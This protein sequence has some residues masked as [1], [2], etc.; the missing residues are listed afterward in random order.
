[1]PKT[2]AVILAGCGHRDGSE[3]HESVCT[4]LALDKAG[5]TVK[6]FAPN[7][8]F[9]VTD[10][11]T[12]KPTGQ[13]RNALQ[14]AAR[15]A[16]GEIQDIKNAKASQFDALVLPGGYGAA[17]ILSNF[18]EKGAQ[19]DVHPEVARLLRETHAAKK[20]IGA[21]CIAPAVV[22][23]ALGEHHPSLTIG[24]DKGTAGA[25]ESMGAKHC[26][27]PVKEHV[28]DKKNKIVTTPAYMLGPS[29]AHVAAGIEKC[30]NE[31]LAMA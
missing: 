27:C 20:P 16:R 19:C 30:V 2:V 3:I 4:L 14:E 29:V 26:D 9:D 1:M 5:V 10:A 13:K 17:K 31:V 12:G 21:I 24:T 11:L 6:C 15:I 8:E 7:V 18:A 25:L 23:R 28:V 22:A